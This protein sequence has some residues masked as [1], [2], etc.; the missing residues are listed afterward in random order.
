MD[1]QDAKVLLAEKLFSD[2]DARPVMQE[3][4]AKKFPAAVTAMPDYVARQTVR[5]ELAKDREE[6]EKERKEREAYRLE[7]ARDAER[8]K[9]IEAGL[10][11]EAE[12]EAVEKLMTDELIGSY[13]VAAREHRR[14]TMPVASP[15]SDA[16]S[17]RV[18]GVNGAGGDDYKGLVENPEQ[19][20]RD[21][22]ERIMD[23][24]AAGK[25][26]KWM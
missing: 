3:L 1:E 2:P 9:V 4:I 12:I 5:D 21:M 17:M 11:G 6:R 18:P 22:T 15:R 24:F 7:K 20:A 8:R 23:D 25:G 26:A 16:R 14:R 19:W 10:V 13:E